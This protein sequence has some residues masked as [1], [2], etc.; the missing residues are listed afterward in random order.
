[1]WEM[2]TNLAFTYMTDRE[3][4]ILCRCDDNNGEPKLFSYFVHRLIS[5]A[6]ESSIMVQ[7]RELFDAVESGALLV[8]T[9]WF[10]FFIPL[11]FYTSE[12]S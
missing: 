1:M 4:H 8:M 5:A 6:Y 12:M 11:H 9:R 7:T 10:Y 3:G 2:C